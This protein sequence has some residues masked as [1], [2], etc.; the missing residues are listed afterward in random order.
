MPVEVTIKSD[1]AG[2]KRILRKYRNAPKEIQ[3]KLVQKWNVT[4]LAFRQLMQDKHLE[5]GTTHDRLAR[6]TSTLYNSLRHEAKVDGK[7]TNVA[8]W[9]LDIVEDYAPT[10][11]YGDPSRNIPAR[12][13]LRDEWKVFQRRFRQDAEDAISEGLR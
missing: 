4:A 2:F 3:T 10:H 1:T 7:D 9:F 5:G 13:N 8:V 11:E 12:M 6:R